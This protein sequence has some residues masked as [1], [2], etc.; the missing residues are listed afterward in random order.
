VRPRIGIT[1][2]LEGVEQ[3]I[4]LRYLRAVEGAG[5][6]P[7]PV[8]LL[9]SDDGVEEFA[10]LLDGLVVIGGPGVVEGIVGSLP[11]ELLPVEPARWESDA[12]ILGTFLE[13]SR[14]ALGICYG[15]QL[16]NAL[17]GGT[18]WAD[19]QRQVPGALV[20]SDRRAGVDHGIHVLPG[21]HLRHVLGTEALLVPTHHLQAIKTLGQGLV[22]AATAP[23][24]VVEALE[25]ADGAFLGVQFHPERMGPEAAP[26]FRHLV[27][28]A[29]DFA[30][31]GAA[32]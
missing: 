15:M 12:R 23:D 5:G 1:T 27:R 21:T 26:L 24:G 25:T 10:A 7:I 3:R 20:H 17:R 13:Q 11:D 18:I 8:P 29:A 2:A 30:G 28:R 22:T 4:D 19:V 32:A 9:E 16:A 14:P 6:L 31:T